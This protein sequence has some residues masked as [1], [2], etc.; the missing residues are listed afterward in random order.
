[1]DASNEGSRLLKRNGGQYIAPMSLKSGKKIVVA[2]SANL[3]IRDMIW[4]V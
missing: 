3:K 2:L 4:L 1:M